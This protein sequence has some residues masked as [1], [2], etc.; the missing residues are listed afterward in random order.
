M[1]TPR[2]SSAALITI[3]SLGILAVCGYKL[4]LGRQKLT[5]SAKPEPREYAVKATTLLEPWYEKLFSDFNLEN[6]TDLVPVLTIL[7]ER[8]QDK[9]AGAEKDKQVLYDRAVELMDGMIS[10]AEERTQA[11]EALL[12]TAAQP[13]TTLETTRSMSSSNDHF[14]AAQ[15]K[16]SMESLKRRKPALDNLFAQM[17]RAERDWNAH[18][19]KNAAPESYKFPGIVP[20]I[21]VDSEP[22][23][24]PLEQKAYDQRKWRRTYYDQNGY[25]RSYSN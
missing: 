16:R 3:I 10:G 15:M 12:K 18:L 5:P 17:S 25:P 11:L 14:L 24:N 20:V 13:R 6:P 19:P 1:D 23:R 2:S 8:I 7:R 21:T 9:R 4:Y 22:R